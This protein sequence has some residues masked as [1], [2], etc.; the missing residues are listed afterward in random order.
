MAGS[1]EALTA[2]CFRVGLPVSLELSGGITIRSTIL[3]WEKD[4]FILVR[5]PSVQG[6]K[7]GVGSGESCLVRFLMEE[8]AYGFASEVLRIQYHPS[9][10]MFL[11]FPE[12]IEQVAFRKSKRFVTN[13]SGKFLDAERKVSTSVVVQDFS[14]KGCLIRLDDPGPSAFK[15]DT[16]YYLTF[17]LFQTEI[18]NLYCTIRNRHVRNDRLLLGVEFSRITPY[19]KETLENLLS[20]LESVSKP[21]PA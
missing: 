19:E 9:P 10:L 14:D 17:T 8:S 1:P 3:G 13:I 20:F 4:R 18:E 15:R 5:L 6:Q 16:V 2:S 11:K 21:G 12:Q 7:S